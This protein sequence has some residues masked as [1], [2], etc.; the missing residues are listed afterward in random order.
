[1]T[2]AAV[3]RVNT[4]LPMGTSVSSKPAMATFIDSVASLHPIKVY[5][6][7]TLGLGFRLEGLALHPC[8]QGSGWAEI[9]NPGLPLTSPRKV[10]F[11]FFFKAQIQSPE[12][13][14]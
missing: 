13:L 7:P 1:M 3:F 11:F 8:S 9:I 12:I 10:F 5:S 2:A 6:A 4:R 14:I